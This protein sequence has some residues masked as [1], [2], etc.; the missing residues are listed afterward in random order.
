M[1]L[2]AERFI[3]QRAA[4]RQKKTRILDAKPRC[5][6]NT[7]TRVGHGRIAGGD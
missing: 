1:R 6:T 2:A 7:Y 4:W 5:Q 3:C